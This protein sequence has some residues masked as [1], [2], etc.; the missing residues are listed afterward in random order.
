MKRFPCLLALVLMVAA[1]I[2]AQVPD[3]TVMVAFTAVRNLDIDPRSDY[4]GGIV[5]GLL[6]YDLTRAP[7]VTLV[8]RGSLDR[9][10]AEQELQL[11]GLVD[12]RTSALK[13]GNLLGADFIVSAE[14][15]AMSA[16]VL[17]TIRV[18]AVATGRSGAFAERGAGENTVHRAAESLVHYLTGSR[19]TFVD[20]SGDRSIV[21]LKNESPGSVALHSN[22]IR[23]EI[24]MDGEFAGYTTGA[25]DVPF[26]IANLPPGKHSIR[27]HL[28]RGFGV[29]KLPEVTFSDWELEFELKPGERKVLR[30]QTRDFNS[31]L[32]GLQYLARD[33]FY[34]KPDTRAKAEKTFELSFQ[35]RAGVVVPVRLSLRPEEKDGILHMS[36]TLTAGDASGAFKLVGEPGKEMEL[37]E[38]VGLVRLYV[39]IDM[40]Y[41]NVYIEFD[42]KR[43][44]IRQNMY[45]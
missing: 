34:W 25:I 31:V 6:L 45:D 29:V 19:P 44:D 11:S 16:E 35:D 14:Y 39:S 30:D 7:G 33:S 9:V 38:I 21:S 15:V 5:Q 3:R 22:I 37:T 23:A 8:D 41:G 42:L 4:I 1:A 13:V 18:V 26:E 12:D 24:F 2:P 27:V 40:K 28:G 20:T 10:L 36:P 43:T 32:Y 17:I